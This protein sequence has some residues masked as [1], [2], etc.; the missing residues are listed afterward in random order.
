MISIIEESRLENGVSMFMAY[1]DNGKFVFSSKFFA[2]SEFTE[3]REIASSVAAD[4]WRGPGVDVVI[5]H[6][7]NSCLRY[8]RPDRGG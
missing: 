3:M 1:D 5:E 6:I 7:E 4:L 8:R 2:V